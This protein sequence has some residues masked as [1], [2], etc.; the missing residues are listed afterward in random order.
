MTG[1]ATEMSHHH[2]RSEIMEETGHMR[3][4]AFGK[5]GGHAD[6]IVAEGDRL[7]INGLAMSPTRF[8]RILGDQPPWR[9]AQM[10]DH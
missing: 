3:V 2:D 5:V 1:D 6:G 4:L 9:L 7:R 8:L 10:P